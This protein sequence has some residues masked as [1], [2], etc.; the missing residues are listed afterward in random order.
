MIV[1][2]SG[3]LDSVLHEILY[4]MQELMHIIIIDRDGILI[5]DNR[6]SSW[7]MRSSATSMDDAVESVI[8][9]L[10]SKAYASTWIE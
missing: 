9:Y 5:M 2:D 4:S 7:L 3:R 10:D 6:L 1:D 8:T